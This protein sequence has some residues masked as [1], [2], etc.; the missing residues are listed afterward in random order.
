M[1]EIITVK[2][3]DLWYGSTQAL[4]NVNINIEQNSITA[5]SAISNC[6]DISFLRN[7]LLFFSSVIPFSKL[8]L[9]LKAFHT[10][11]Y[12]RPAR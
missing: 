3:L 9:T 6:T 7:P 2:D 12:S 1:N 5:T 11:H 4:K 8:C 10:M